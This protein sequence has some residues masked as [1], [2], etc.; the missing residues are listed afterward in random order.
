L[1][2]YEQARGRP[3][4]MDE[5]RAAAAAAAWILAFNGRWNAALIVH[6]ICDHATIA[7]VREHQEDY[8]TL[9]WP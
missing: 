9:S 1:Q 6:G 3:L 5:R 4:S 8:L 2:D 7:L